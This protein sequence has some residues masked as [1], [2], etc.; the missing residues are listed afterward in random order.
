MKK[1]LFIMLLLLSTAF[2][3]WESTAFLAIMTSLMILILFYMVA[4]AFQART[5]K[6]MVKDEFFQLIALILMM[7]LFFGANN[8]IDVI[9]Q[10]FSL[11]GTSTNL[12]D[13][14]ILKLTTTLNGKGGIKEIYK[15]IREADADVGLQASSGFSCS[16]MSVGY[17]VSGCGGYTMLQTP[18]S[19]VGSILGFSI[20]E[21]T[22]MI[23][24]LTLSK[25]YALTLLLPIGI[26]L[27]T[28]K[29]TRGAGGLLLGVALSLHLLMPMG[30]VFMD[31]FAEAFETYNTETITGVKPSIKSDYIGSSK[32]LSV[33]EC[34]PADTG[35]DNDNNAIKTYTTF[36][37]SIRGFL[38]IILVKATLTPVVALFMFVG[39]VRMISALGGAAIDVS[40]LGRF[41]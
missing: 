11:S 7:V 12:Q 19:I 1:I 26:V 28:F 24:L 34:E 9:S 21:L 39:G 2:A 18:F 14:A 33:V 20:G 36:R 29:V 3:G 10:G 37:K 27:R 15:D 16:I 31:Y 17:F 32:S 13:A 22:V 38:Y 35:E 40:A 5:L 30:V 6:I 25:T 8:L 4:F 23:H 41:V